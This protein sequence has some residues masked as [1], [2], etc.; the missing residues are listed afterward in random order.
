MVLDALSYTCPDS[1][2]TG[3]FHSPVIVWASKQSDLVNSGGTNDY[4]KLKRNVIPT[5]Y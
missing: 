2:K 4:L 3:P 1:D 5:C